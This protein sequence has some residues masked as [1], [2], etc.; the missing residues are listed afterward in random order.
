MKC[1]EII[2]PEL[3]LSISGARGLEYTVVIIKL[4]KSA[5]IKRDKINHGQYRA[6]IMVSYVIGMRNGLISV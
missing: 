1:V 5:E 3:S 6:F 2:F 4:K